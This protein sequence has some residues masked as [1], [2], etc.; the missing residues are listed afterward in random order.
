MQSRRCSANPRSRALRY[1]RDGVVAM[2]PVLLLGPLGILYMI[3][4]GYTAMPLWHILLGAAL[5]SSFGI[6]RAALAQVG[7][8]GLQAWSAGAALARGFEN[9]RHSIGAHGL[10]ILVIGQMAGGL[11]A[12]LVLY[13]LG[14]WARRL[15]GY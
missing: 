9:L 6:S 12:A 2:H 8:I 10:S 4:V 11:A 15:I 14:Y 5:I 3:A 1:E 13:G 7:P